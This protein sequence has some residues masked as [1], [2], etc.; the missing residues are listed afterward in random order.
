MTIRLSLEDLRARVAARRQ[1]RADRAAALR[2]RGVSLL[3]PKSRGLAEAPPT[4][5]ARLLPWR[6]REDRD[7]S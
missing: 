2:D 7:A 1:Q 5:A 4:L 3:E 6:R